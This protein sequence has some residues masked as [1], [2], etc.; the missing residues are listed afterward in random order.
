MI[1]GLGGVSAAVL[2]PGDWTL[3]QIIRTLPST[4]RRHDIEVSAPDHFLASVETAQIRRE[5]LVELLS[6]VD[7]LLMSESAVQ[8][9]Q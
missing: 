1:V 7:V 8:S 5:V 3:L 4:V 2:A 6:E 9:N